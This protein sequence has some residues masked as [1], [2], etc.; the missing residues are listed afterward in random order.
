M[1]REPYLVAEVEELEDAVGDA[2]AAR[3]LT[4]G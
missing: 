4:D 1:G 2:D 3:A